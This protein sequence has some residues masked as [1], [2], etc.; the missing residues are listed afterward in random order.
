MSANAATAP[1]DEHES[2]ARPWSRNTR[3]AMPCCTDL[4]T[5]AYEQYMQQLQSSANCIQCAKNSF[6]TLSQKDKKSH[7][8]FS[9][10]ALHCWHIS[11]EWGGTRIKDDITPNDGHPEPINRP[12]ILAQKSCSRSSANS[13][14]WS[15][16]LWKLKRFQRKS[17]MNTP[18]SECPESVTFIKRSN[19]PQ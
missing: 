5:L 19:K 12:T 9:H 11:W 15:H 17:L 1:Q 14:Q 8:S 7:C 13:S 3:K 18:Q 16:T 2:A 4:S 6:C 10:D